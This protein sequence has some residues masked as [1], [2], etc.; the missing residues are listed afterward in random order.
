MAVHN[1][2]LQLDRAIG[3]GHPNLAQVGKAMQVAE[4]VRTSLVDLGF[5]LVLDENEGL[6]AVRK[7]MRRNQGATGTEENLNGVQ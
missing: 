3:P 2:S 5:L 7:R 4:E 1:L 6:M